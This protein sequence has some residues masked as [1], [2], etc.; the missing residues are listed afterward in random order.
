MTESADLQSETES[1]PGVPGRRGG[2]VRLKI[3]S[4]LAGLG[5]MG[6]AVSGLVLTYLGNV[7]SGYPITPSLGVYAWN[8]GI[9][10]GLGAV[11]GPPLVWTMLRRVPLWRTFAEP[12]LAGIVGSGVAMFLPPPLFPIIVPGAIFAS[13][14]CL[15]YVYRD[16]V[17]APSGEERASA[18][19]SLH[20]RMREEPEGVANRGSRSSRGSHSLKVGRGTED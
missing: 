9:M 8:A 14:G 19:D 20:P 15:A 6:G 18:E 13:A 10:A 4:A 3:T 7:I 12:A 5:A 2:L 1:F 17:P 11:F 16:P